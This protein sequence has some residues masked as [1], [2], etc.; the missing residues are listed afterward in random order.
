MSQ[1]VTLLLLVFLASFCGSRLGVKNATLRQP[2]ID[3]RLNGTFY[4]P[5]NCSEALVELDWKQKAGG[6]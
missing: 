4:G 5:T 1:R 3:I 2:P 6:K